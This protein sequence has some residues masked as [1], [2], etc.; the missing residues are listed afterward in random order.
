[1]FSKKFLAFIYSEGKC[2]VINVILD[3]KCNKMLDKD[4]TINQDSYLVK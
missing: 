3:F 4:N 2:I 1:M